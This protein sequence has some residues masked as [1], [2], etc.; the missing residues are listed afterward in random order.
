MAKAKLHEVLAV[1]GELE[2]VNKSVL[3]EAKHTFKAKPDHFLGSIKTYSPFDANDQDVMAPEY[4]EM[5]TTIGDKLAYVF[6]H[7]ARYLDAVA[8]KEA[9]NQTA[10]ADIV[11]GDGRVLAKDIPAT[12]LLGLETKIKQWKEVCQEIP[13]LAPGLSWKKD[14]AR[15][16]GVYVAE[17][18]EETRRTKKTVKSKVLYDATKEH[19]AQI[20]KWAEDIPVGKFVTQRWCGMLSPADKSALLA[21]LDELGRAVK[22]ARQRANCAEIVD[23]K[24]GKTLF[25]FLANG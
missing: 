17:H 6:E 13:T 2:G 11:L 24:I 19:P 15:G 21:R 20:E 12:F 3:D 7:V 10:R 4:K 22:Q 5:V 8:Q 14:E 16:K 23:V 9:T 1:E 18:P 25:D